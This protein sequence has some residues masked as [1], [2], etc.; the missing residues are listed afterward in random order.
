MPSRIVCRRPDPSC[1]LI[2][3]GVPCLIGSRPTGASAPNDGGG[4]VCASERS[5]DSDECE[6]C[7]L[8]LRSVERRGDGV[9]LIRR[10]APALTRLPLSSLAGAVAKIAA[11]ASRPVRVPTGM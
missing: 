6:R 2:A 4:G 1:A 3:A 10:Y 8:S 5:S 7:G 11:C 9:M